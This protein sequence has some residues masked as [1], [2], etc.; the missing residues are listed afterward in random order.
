M[1]EEREDGSYTWFPGGLLKPVISPWTTTWTTAA[2]VRWRCTS[3]RPPPIRNAAT[4]TGS[5]ATRWP[6]CIKLDRDWKRERI[7]EV[8]DLEPDERTF[9][10]SNRGA[11]LSTFDHRSAQ[12]H[13]VFDGICGDL[14]DEYYP[15][16]R[17]G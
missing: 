6:V 9:P 2:A 10:R 3:V 17:A 1:L 5:C 4:P 8:L 11:R 12:R 13:E 14:M 15:G 7:V 16:W